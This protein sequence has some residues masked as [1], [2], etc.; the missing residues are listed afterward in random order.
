MNHKQD[1]DTPR[2]DIQLFFDEIGVVLDDNQYRDAISLVDMYH[3]YVRQHQVSCFRLQN[4]YL[5]N[6]PAYF[7]YRKFR[8]SEDEFSQSRPKALLQFAGQAIL[9]GVQERKRKWTWG[10]FAE[11]R[12]DRN[13]YVALFQK[14]LLNSLSGQVS[15]FSLKES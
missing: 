5:L 2:F 9:Q 11:R 13:K 12:D 3:V 4:V 8:P 14:K 7:Q 10:Y 6:S 1:K 15:H